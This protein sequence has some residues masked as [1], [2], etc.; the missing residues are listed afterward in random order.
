MHLMLEIIVCD[1][2]KCFPLHGHHCMLDK[3]LRWCDGVFFH[4]GIN[5]VFQCYNLQIVFNYGMWWYMLSYYIGYLYVGISL[6]INTPLPLLLCFSVCHLKMFLPLHVHLSL[7]IIHWDD[8]ATS[9]PTLVLTL[10]VISMSK[11]IDCFLL[12]VVIICCCMLSYYSGISL[13]SDLIP[14]QYS[15]SWFV[16]FLCMLFK[17]V[18]SITC[19]S[20]HSGQVIEMMWQCPPQLWY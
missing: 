14:H 7:W 19:S 2:R 3:S 16:V 18:S 4:F 13:C 12:M 20:L 15:P 11:F 9:S 6:Q 10:S 8:V 5:I 17:K 1:L